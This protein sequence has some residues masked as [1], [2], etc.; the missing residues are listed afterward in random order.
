MIIAFHASIQTVVNV[1]FLCNIKYENGLAI[2]ID[3]RSLLHPFSVRSSLFLIV[4]GRIGSQ[5]RRKRETKKKME[6]ANKRSV[7][8]YMYIYIFNA[9]CAWHTGKHTIKI[10]HILHIFSAK[11]NLNRGANRHIS[12]AAMTATNDLHCQKH[13]IFIIND[14]L[15][16][17]LYI[18]MDKRQSNLTRPSLGFFFWHANASE[19]CE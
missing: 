8:I 12:Y 4:L 10:I 6:S 15:K 9:L 11:I 13:I 3:S 14:T 1:F 19:R 7:S 18:C 17:Y 2:R 5:E 16:I